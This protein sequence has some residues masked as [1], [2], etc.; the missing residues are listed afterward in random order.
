MEMIICELR[1]R[2]RS[3]RRHRK[4]EAAPSWEIRDQ[5]GRNLGP[6]VLLGTMRRVQ[7]RRRSK[8]LPSYQRGAKRGRMPHL[9]V[10][11]ERVRLAGKQRKY[12]D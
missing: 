12:Q 5:K 1:E 3:R 8:K 9:W 10:S 7:G 6:R 4:D 2:T 11:V